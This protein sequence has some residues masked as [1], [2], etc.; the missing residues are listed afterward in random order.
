MVTMVASI[1]PKTYLCKA[2]LRMSSD[3]DCG[4]CPLTKKRD[5]C[6]TQLS[7]SPSC[8]CGRVEERCAGEKVAT[9][10]LEVGVEVRGRQ[11]SRHCGY[12]TLYRADA[13]VVAGSAVQALPSRWES[14]G[15]KPR[16]NQGR[17]RVSINVPSRISRVAQT[18]ETF[19]VVVGST[20]VGWGESRRELGASLVH[21]LFLPH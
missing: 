18:K 7:S 1:K 6:F 3:K 13:P 19:L 9:I 4:T 17:Q 5:S 16:S 12:A 11:E 2:R 14:R 15:P 8:C 21:G 10:S 20:E